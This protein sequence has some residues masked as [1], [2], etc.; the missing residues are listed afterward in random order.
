MNQS[1]GTLPDK[2]FTKNTLCYLNIPFRFKLFY[3]VPHLFYK[4][5]GQPK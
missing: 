1:Y 2:Y 3:F 4:N 5:A